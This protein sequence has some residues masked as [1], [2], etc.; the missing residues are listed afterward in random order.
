MRSHA[1]VRTDLFPR[2]PSQVLLTDFFGGVAQVDLELNFAVRPTLV[3]SSPG[4]SSDVRE[5]LPSRHSIFGTNCT[6]SKAGNKEEPA[7]LRTLS[8]WVA[9]GLVSTLVIFTLGGT[10]PQNRP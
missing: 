2:E 5:A 3:S 8:A 6:S 10:G 9:I 1:G 7:Q 4:P